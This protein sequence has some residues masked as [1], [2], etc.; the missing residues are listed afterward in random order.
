MSDKG[1]AEP[2]SEVDAHRAERGGL[3]LGVEV[4][5]HLADLASLVR[6]LHHDAL[7]AVKGGEAGW[8]TPGWAGGSSRHSLVVVVLAILHLA[9]D[10]LLEDRL[11]P[12]DLRR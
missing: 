5:A 8:Q 3:D 2:G 7:P 9:L 4:D 12:N 6:E 1:R 11:V 10:S